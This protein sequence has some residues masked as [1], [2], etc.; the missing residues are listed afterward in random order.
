[1]GFVNPKQPDAICLLDR[2]L[3][4]LKQ[5]PHVWFH[6]FATFIAKLGFVYARSDALLFG[7][8]QGDELAYLL[9]YVDDM[10]LT[11]SSTALMDRIIGRLC[12]EFPV[13]DVGPLRFFLSINV[14]HSVHGFA[15]SQQ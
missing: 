4:G 13:R 7:L 15:L 2:S 3:Y 9:L 10:V 1:M 6:Q 8:R 5:A 11:S 12:A 14:T